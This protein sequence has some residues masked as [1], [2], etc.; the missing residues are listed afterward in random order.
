M[1]CVEVDGGYHSDALQIVKDNDRDKYLLEKHGIITM[2]FSNDE[3]LYNIGS[4]IKKIGA[5]VKRN[6]FKREIKRKNNRKAVIQKS[7]R[8]R[9]P[10]VL[11]STT[12]LE[13]LKASLTVPP[14]ARSSPRR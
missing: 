13:E 3:V 2:R 1:L 5:Y 6:K 11:R 8:K 14:G 9:R 7:G 12:R 10:K 4:V